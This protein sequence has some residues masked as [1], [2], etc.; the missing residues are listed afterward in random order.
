MG[1][2]SA[3]CTR[4]DPLNPDH[5][6]CRRTPSSRPGRGAESVAPE[7]IRRATVIQVA[8]V[9]RFQRM[10][11]EPTSSAKRSAWPGGRGRSPR[12]A[13]SG[14]AAPRTAI[15]PAP[16]Y[17]R[18]T[19]RSTASAHLP[20]VPPNVTS[21]RTVSRPRGT[22]GPGPS[23]TPCRAA[24]GS[25]THFFQDSAPRPSHRWTAPPWRPPAS[26]QSNPG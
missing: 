13:W 23:R 10:S 15:G 1:P 21:E 6:R 9:A 12:T 26:R 17:R 14:C 20:A 16:L 11:A 3:R 8:R 2:P 25:P 18:R 7:P 4:S 24:S 22:G 5:G 19:V